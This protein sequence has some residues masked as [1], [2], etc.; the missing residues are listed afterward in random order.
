MLPAEE[1]MRWAD[2]H[3]KSKI[4]QEMKDL[5][6]EFTK[7]LPIN[8]EIVYSKNFKQFNGG[9]KWKIF[10]NYIDKFDGDWVKHLA[11]D[12][13]FLRYGYRI[14]INEVIIKKKEEGDEDM[15][16]YKEKDNPKIYQLGADGK[17]HHIITAPVF[18]GLYGDLSKAQI[19]E[20][21]SIP[22]EDIGF[23]IYD[24]KSFADIISELFGRKR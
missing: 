10:D 14:I 9:F 24:K 21:D 22:K 13:N 7:R 5:G 17:Y 8:Y 4:T 2:Y 18:E 19:V 12:Y 6:K 1:W 20:L 15:T 23:T 11:E 16:F 3:N